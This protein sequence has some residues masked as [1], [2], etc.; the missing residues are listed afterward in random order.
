MSNTDKK[1]NVQEMPMKKRVVY[2]A[3]FGGYDKLLEPKYADPNIDYICFTDDKNITS[4]VWRIIYINEE[5]FDGNNARL[6]RKYKFLPHVYFPEYEESLYVDGNIEITT[7]NLSYAFEYALSNSDISI[8]KHADRDC[9]Y[10]EAY[11][12]IRIKKGDP[13]KIEEQMLFYQSQGYPEKNGLYENNVIFRKHKNTLVKKVMNQWYEAIT[14]HSGRDQLSLC[15]LLWLNSLSCKVFQWGPKYSNKFFRIK[16][17]CSEMKLPLHKRASLHIL[18][19]SK[20]KWYYGFLNKII[21]CIK[22]IRNS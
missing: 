6:N 21:N 14:I 7:K 16:F 3:I 5:G 2:T 4:S 11:A 15:Y 20:A 12:C 18:L 8:P 19:N 10:E 22:D 13:N 9:I 1:N 17:H